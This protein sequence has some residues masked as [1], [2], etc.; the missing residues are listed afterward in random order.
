ML[1][2]L[3]A[4]LLG[5]PAEIKT[6]IVQGSVE[7]QPPG[8]AFEP[9]K[10]GMALAI[11]S[12]V[13]TGAGGKA[14]F[15]LGAGFELR[16]NEK[17][18]LVL[19]TEKKLLLKQG[20]VFLRVPKSYAPVEVNTE[21]HPMKLDECVAEITF[22]PR[23]PN[24]A[25]AQTSFMVLEG[26]MQAFSKKFSP[27]ITSGWV[28]TGYGSQLNTPD[29]IRCASADTAWV[30]SLLVERGRVDEEVGMRSDELLSVLSKENPDPAEPALRSLGELAAP[31]VARFLG[32]SVVET[33]VQRRAVAARILGDGVTVKTAGLLVPLL[34]HKESEVRIAGGRG[35]ARVA[36]KDLGFN[37]AF[38]KGV[39]V[40]A[41]VKAWEEW[42]KQ[43]AK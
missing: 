34:S 30:H 18:E 12:T 41:G 22:I 32:R 31:A 38:W 6:T 27:V 9:L 8:G 33:Q 25:P 36:G 29:T 35:L 1:A 20:R 39:N 15:E 7:A 2:L 23:V 10:P 40:D 11:G 42:V 13:R 26:K 43:N 19:E 14:L 16:I 28:A 24:G 5:G 21:L 3:A 17:A 37:D 4:L